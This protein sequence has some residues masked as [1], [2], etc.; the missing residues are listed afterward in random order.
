M[1]VIYIVV[2][3]FVFIF[4]NV[5]V[6]LYR[7]KS[8]VIEVYKLYKGRLLKNYKEFII[9]KKKICNIKFVLRILCF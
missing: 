9:R 6:N 7:L 4:V 3:F 5:F 1:G 2:V 8:E